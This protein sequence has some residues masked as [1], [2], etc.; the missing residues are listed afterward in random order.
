MKRFAT[1]QDMA[2]HKT[3]EPIIAEI[4]EHQRVRKALMKMI[5]AINNKSAAFVRRL[6]G[7]STFTKNDEELKAMNAIR[8][9]AR[10]IFKQIVT[11][12][13]DSSVDCDPVIYNLAEQV[14]KSGQISI[15]QWSLQKTAIEKRM[16]ELAK[17][18]PCQE[19]V[20]NTRGFSIFGLAIVIGETGNISNYPSAAHLRKRAGVSPPA[21]YNA[22]DKNGKI[23][24][25]IPRARRSVFW[26]LSDAMEK[27][28]AYV[29]GSSLQ[30][31]REK[32][33][34]S[35]VTSP[36]AWDTR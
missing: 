14:V 6:L 19:F 30:A 20:K 31:R 13:L 36:D 4:Q 33:G 8:D 7:F 9:K 18:L 11:G 15:K 28:S 5:F 10:K 25:M 1:E 22:P 29:K 24:C 12:K 17:Q 23:V 32:I 34:A 35:Y 3:L 21:V 2:R 26:T 16:I 27:S